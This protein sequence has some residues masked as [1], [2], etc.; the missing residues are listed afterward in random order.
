MRVT[1]FPLSTIKEVPADAE[2]ASHRLML[3]A[4]LI[5]KVASGL[6]TWKPWGLKILRNVENIVREEMDKAGAIELLMPTIQP[7]ELWHESGRW[8]QFGPQ[9]LRMQDRHERDFCYG[10]THE[11]VITDYVRNEIQSYKQL[12]INFYQIQSKVRDEIRPRFGVMRAREFLM[13]DAYSFHLD[14][15]SL[16]E[17]YNKMHA[18]YSNIFTRL[19]LNFRAVEADSGAIG[20]SQSVE[21]HVL[22]DSGEDEIAFSDQSDYAANVE[23]ASALVSDKR[24]ESSGAATEKL[25]TPDVKTI[26]DVSDHLGVAMNQCIKTMLVKG[27]EEPVVALLLRGDHQL[28]EIKASNHPL[29]A[30]PLTLVNDAAIKSLASCGAGSVGPID[31]GAP[32]LVDQEAANLVDFVCGANEDGYH[33]VNVNFGDDLPEP[34]N[35]DLRNVVAGDP[36]PDGQGTLEIMRGIE[37]GHIFQLGTKYSEAM[38]C[39][40]LNENGKATTLS[41]GCYG[42][43]VSRIV[44]AAIE[45]N[46][47]DNG[48]IWPTSMTPYEVVIAPIN[49]HKSQRLREAV[50]TLYT[51]LKT[52]GINVLL[53]DRKIRP[54]VM[55]ADQELIGL[56]HR[57]VF[58]EKGLDAGELEYKA[59]TASESQQV[60]MTEIV[61]FLQKK[62]N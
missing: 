21:F 45:Q 18:A 59:R 62:I 10:P 13:K 49:L 26:K 22:A 17:G 23:K 34:E 25:A 6:Y 14:S 28:N 58:S 48:I 19:E 9:L 51:E 27:A 42:I 35:A 53:D 38:K 4:G 5:R 36:S 50:E 41:M 11:E 56:P 8:D 54:G 20:G 31:L 3:R 16:E 60:P 33:F 46:H 32:I 7:A 2:L 39:Q 37:V 30:S 55:F 57:V 44:A 12:P 40:V 24:A 47:D 29:V 1:N 43:G 61:K 15:E 52:A